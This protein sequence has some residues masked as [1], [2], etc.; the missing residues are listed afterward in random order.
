[1]NEGL[2]RAASVQLHIQQK[3][4]QYTERATT[5]HFF[6]KNLGLSGFGTAGVVVGFSG[7]RKFHGLPHN[8]EFQ[9]CTKRSLSLLFQAA[10][11][12]KS[13]ASAS[14]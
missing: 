7:K 4:N 8:N 9:E 13:T 14:C 12:E 3:N 11:V 5:C 6:P 1:M 2:S 10:S